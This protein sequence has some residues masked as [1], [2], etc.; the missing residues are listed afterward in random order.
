MTRRPQSRP[1]TLDGCPG[2]GWLRVRQNLGALTFEGEAR[3]D[4]SDTGDLSNEFEGTATYNGP[5]VDYNGRVSR[6]RAADVEITRKERRGRHLVITL[7][8][9]ASGIQYRLPERREIHP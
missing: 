8:G 5:I 9:D 1:V 2:T 6:V 7:A 3:I 4:M